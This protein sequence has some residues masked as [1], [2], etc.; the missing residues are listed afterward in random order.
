MN[1]AF[2]AGKTRVIVSP[3]FTAPVPTNDSYITLISSTMTN[4]TDN[5]DWPG[6]PDY[7]EDRFV[8]FSYR[9]KYDDNE[10]SLMA[11]FT[12]I[13]YIPKQGGFFIAGDEEFRLSIY[14]SR[15]YGKFCVQNIGL[16]IPLPTNANRLLRDYKIS[17]LEILF[18]ES[19]SVAVKVLES[20]SSG[21]VKAQLPV[22]VIITLTIINQESRIKHY[23]KL[24]QLEYM[25]KCL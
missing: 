20:V 9:F 25:T 7:L 13:A 10:Y 1:V 2:A 14:N 18:R 23:Q 19:D 4:E 5:L 16:V 12:Q 11:P 15:F 21:E 22:L 24:K 3:A 8:R 6:D 17:E